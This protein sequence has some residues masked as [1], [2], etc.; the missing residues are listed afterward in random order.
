MT[1]REMIS[2]VRSVHKLLGDSSITDRAILAELKG[3]AKLLIKQQTDKRKLW[4]SPSLFSVIPCMEMK[5]VPLADCCDYISDETIYRSID[6]I[7]QI[8]EGNFGLLVQ[9]VFSIDNSV[10]FNPSSPTDFINTKKLKLDKACF[11]IENDYLYVTKETRKVKVVGYFED[12]AA[13]KKFIETCDCGGN[14]DK[15]SK[16]KSALDDEF[17]CPGYLTSNVISIVSKT[18]LETYF[19]IKTDITSDS[20]DDQVNEK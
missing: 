7:P 8:S 10:K 6:K 14:K 5:E 9:G 15:S 4:T 13:L 2:R 3:S 11:W 19:R 12:E 16:C 18:L 1:N 17:K 20:K